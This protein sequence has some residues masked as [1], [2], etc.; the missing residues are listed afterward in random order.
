M[1][2]GAAGFLAIGGVIVATAGLLL[3]G[4]AI[5]YRLG[6]QAAPEMYP[7]AWH[8]NGLP[9]ARELLPQILECEQTG[10]VL[11]GNGLLL[12]QA[13]ARQGDTVPREL[14]AAIE[15]LNA[16]TRLLADQLN[17]LREQ[18]D[19]DRLPIA[20]TKQL[21]SEIVPAPS[22]T[23]SPQQAS[24]FLNKEA[25]NAVAVSGGLLTAEEVQS[26]GNST[27]GEP[28]EFC[29]HAKR[30]FPYRCQQFVS[31]VEAGDT[32]RKGQPVAVWCHDISVTGIS[33]FWPD[34][35]QFERLIISVG[36]PDRPIL[37]QAQ[38]MQS[39]VVYMLGD[40][41]YLLGCRFTGRLDSPATGEAMVSRP[42]IAAESAIAAVSL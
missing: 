20:Q 15:Q 40:V 4:L 5:G 10:N 14:S 27:D 41:R 12:H 3:L 36:Q 29:D 39:K 18:A 16:N 34:Q 17:H 25:S 42:P 33:F 23:M 9:V 1:M 38:V 31:V 30:R 13:A 8:E 22:A 28:V 19:P 35:P 24:G 37:M 26:L 2:P 21:A 32:S 6:L 11:L 7:T